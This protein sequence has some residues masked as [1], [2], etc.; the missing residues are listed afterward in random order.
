M[1]NIVTIDR[2]YGSGASD[3]ARTLG[4]RL[5]WDVWDERLTAEIARLMECDCRTVAMLEERRD[6]LYCRMLKAFFRGSAEGVQNAPRLK[7]VDADCIRQVAERVVLAAAKDGHSVLVGRGS[8]YY[9]RTRP[10]AFHVFIHASTEDKVR[11]LRSTGVSERE[12]RE[13]VDTV[14]RDRAAFTRR[15]FKAKWPDWNRFHLLIDSA[16]GDEGVVDRILHGID[17]VERLSQ[18]SAGEPR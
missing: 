10:D 15:Y 6:P 3:I 9:L 5:G 13:L 12:A 16:I 18:R 4:V 17:M 7:M 8:A 14:D 1:I 11:R 2:E